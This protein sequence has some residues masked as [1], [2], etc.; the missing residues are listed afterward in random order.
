MIRTYNYPLKP[1]KEQ[2]QILD[3][4]RISCQQLY[5]GALEERISAW[6]KQHRSVSYD[7]QTISSTQLREESEEW[8]EIPVEI[9]RSALHRVNT[10]YQGFFR[11]V[12]SGGKPG[13]PRFKSRDRYDSFSFPGGK[14]EI[15]GNKIWFPKLGWV[16]F[17]NYR[18]IPKDA[19]I[20]LVSVRKTIK[21]WK[22]GLVLDLGEAPAKIAIKSEIGLDVGLTTFATLSDGA[23][24][25]NPRFFR[26]SEA[27]LA[28]QQRN[29]AAKK[30][31]SKSRQR[32]KKLVAKTYLEIHNQRLDY[33]RKEAKKLVKQYDLVCFE[34]LEIGNMV[35]S[36][37]AKSINDA[38]WGIFL[39][40]IRFKAEE[41]GSYA[42]GVNPK[43][44]S[45]RC[46]NPKCGKKVKKT[47]SD[48]EHICPYCGLRIDRDI[49]A[50]LNILAL[51]G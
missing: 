20:K 16:K 8:E 48:R 40:C 21:G 18:L 37:L 14:T 50:A 25:E 31:G 45:Q 2:D 7:D 19:V 51:G 49:N 3:Q 1:T 28:R 27:R 34:S 29:L 30:R 39:N 5:N 42:I 22:V 26:E 23:K 4:W 35:Q 32:A 15:Q 10:S 46:S 24:I 43:G 17:H 13:F 9:S 11:R 47:L 44:T 41:A 38:A 12:K 6:K 36:K 33:A